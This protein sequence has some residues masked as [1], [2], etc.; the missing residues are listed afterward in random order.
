MCVY[1][2]ACVYLYLYIC[3]DLFEQRVY[4]VRTFLESEDIFDHRLYGVRKFLESEDILA[5][6]H[7][8]RLV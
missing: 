1:V 3:E 7:L 4:G 2:C 5:G 8:Q 6:P